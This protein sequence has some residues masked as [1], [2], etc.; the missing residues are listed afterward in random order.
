MCLF[1]I[2]LETDIDEERR[3]YR[4]E[5]LLKIGCWDKGRHSLTLGRDDAPFNQVPVG[6]RAFLLVLIP[7][8]VSSSYSTTGT[9]LA[10]VAV[11]QSWMPTRRNE[12]KATKIPKKNGCQT[13]AIF[14][15][16]SRN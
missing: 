8:L 14:A 15:L 4:S 10:P 3:I 5:F 7:F 11:Q 1:K 13:F 12:Q 16:L 2:V 6:D 9:I